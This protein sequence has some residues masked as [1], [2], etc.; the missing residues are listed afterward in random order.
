MYIPIHVDRLRVCIRMGIYLVTCLC[1]AHR[2]GRVFSFVFVGGMQRVW[3]LFSSMTESSLLR[4]DQEKLCCLFVEVLCFLSYLETCALPFFRACTILEGA[5]AARDTAARQRQEIQGEL[6]RVSGLV[7]SSE[8]RLAV[9][10]RETEDYARMVAKLTQ[11]EQACLEC[12]GPTL[13]LS[14]SLPSPMPKNHKNPSKTNF[15]VGGSE[16]RKREDYFYNESF[17]QRQKKST[18]LLSLRE[19]HP[20]ADPATSDGDHQVSINHKKDSHYDRSLM[21]KTRKDSFLTTRAKGWTSDQV[22]EQHRGFPLRGSDWRTSAL[23]G[24]EN[25]NED[26]FSSL[27]NLLMREHTAL[28]SASERYEGRG[29]EDGSPYH[30][31]KTRGDSRETSSVPSSMMSTPS[32]GGGRIT[33]QLPYHADSERSLFSSWGKAELAGGNESSRSHTKKDTLSPS[34]LIQASTGGCSFWIDWQRTR[35]ERLIT[36]N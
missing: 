22:L 1:T 4:E 6:A 10:H 31:P 36:N 8:D 14:G 5:H 15:S 32:F 26:R 21:E 20:G 28:A 3:R 7:S 33:R 16:E 9:L 24:T 2:G 18:R 30:F 25:G 17:I 11:R 35:E 19:R 23:S 13:G 34:S 27:E 12:L 29:N